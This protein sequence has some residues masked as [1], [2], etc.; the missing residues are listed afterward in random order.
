MRFQRHNWFAV[1]RWKLYKLSMLLT[2]GRIGGWGLYLK[3]VYRICDSFEEV[4]RSHVKS[5]RLLSA[6]YIEHFAYGN[7]YGGRLRPEAVLPRRYAYWL[8]DV[9][10]SPASGA[11][12]ICGERVLI[13]SLGTNMEFWDLGGMV[14]VMRKPRRAS[15]SGPVVP[16]PSLSYYHWL[17]I[18]LPQLLI[19]QREA[20]GKVKV[21][22]SRAPAGYVTS[23]LGF[24][25]FAEESLIRSDE[26]LRVD[27]T[28]LV[29]R[30]S[31]AGVVFRED[32]AVLRAAIL[33]R[34]SPLPRKRTRRIY[35]SRRL[36]RNRA[37]QNEGEVERLTERYGFDVCYFERMA[38]G[39]QMQAVAEASVVMGVH[40]AGL[41]N[42]V[43]GQPGLRVVEILNPDWF[44]A[45]FSQIALQLGFDYKSLLL[46]R[47][48]QGRLE[49][50]VAEIESCLASL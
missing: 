20:K 29:A 18:A 15:V 37:I 21:L 4:V 49:A 24:L 25:G 9:A 35:V 44:N 10:V 17:L 33:P 22:L 16:L 32:L 41:S 48:P 2:L 36:E 45:C 43:C 3:V 39:E 28:V 11:M 8:K 5:I 13:E 46:T 47:T 38:F 31:D 42:I 50:P 26:P 19:A 14:D 30:N 40:G 12:W 27:E 23:A 1:L 6:A 7:D 34:L